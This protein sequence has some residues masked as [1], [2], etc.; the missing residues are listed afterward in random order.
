MEHIVHRRYKNK[1]LFGNPL[2]LPYG[3]V[4]NEINGFLH[5]QEGVPVC[6]VNSEVAKMYTA[7]NDDN[8]GLERGKL[9]YAI[10][11]SRKNGGISKVGFRFSNKQ[12]DVIVRHYQRFI[13]P[14]FDMIIF[15]DRFFNAPVNE[16]QEMAKEL[17]IKVE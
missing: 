15:N 9:T 6:T 5:T 4:L 11:Y 14:E 1:D 2:N 8:E 16:L 12:C 7:R 13:R 3:T 17:K 10:A